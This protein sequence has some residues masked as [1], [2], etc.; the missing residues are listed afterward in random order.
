MLYFLW[1]LR[2]GAA[3][4][5]I[6]SKKRIRGPHR[7]ISWVSEAGPEGRIKPGRERSI[8]VKGKSKDRGQ[9]VGMH[10]G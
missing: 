2:P 6:Q 9:V 1:K 8:P 10:T 3:M 7:T 4:G 5:L